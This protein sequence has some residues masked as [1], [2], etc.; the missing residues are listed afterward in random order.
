MIDGVIITPL[1]RIQDEYGEVMHMLRS[2]APH[3]KQ[4]G[5]VYFSVTNPGVVKAWKLHKEMTLNIAVPFG[6]LDFVIYDPRPSS[7]T[8]QQIFIK[9][10][11]PENYDLLTVPNGVWAGVKAYQGQPAI[12]ANCASLVHDNNEVERLEKNDPFISFDWNKVGL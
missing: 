2:D 3:F 4:F 1:K 12:L 11:G 5:E 6:S 9:K 8:Y 10:L 7:S